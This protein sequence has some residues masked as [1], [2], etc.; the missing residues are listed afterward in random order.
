MKLRGQAIKSPKPRTALSAIKAQSGIVLVAS[1]IVLALLSV[2]GANAMQ[3]SGLEEKMA[4]N[5]RDRNLAFQAAESALIAGEAFLD[6]K[7]E[8]DLPTFNCTNGF[9]PQTKTGCLAAMA[10]DV[11]NQAATWTNAG[12]V[13]YTVDLANVTVKPRYIIEQLPCKDTDLSG[14]CNT[15]GDAWVYR[16]TASATG[17]T[18]DSLVMVQSLYEIPVN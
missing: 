10:N 6:G 8:E 15:I 1:L 2:I 18:P 5:M 9:Y 17:T 4:G 13:E 11:W 12:S 16:I 14:S 7:K 3:S